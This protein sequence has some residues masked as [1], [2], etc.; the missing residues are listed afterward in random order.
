MGM[1]ATIKLGDYLWRPLSDSD[2]DTA[3]VCAL[4]NEGRF[5]RMFYSQQITPE[6]HKKFI[7]AADERDEINWLIQH[8]DGTPLGVSSIYHVDRANRK[9]ECGRTVMLDPRLFHMNFVA[10]G[11]IAQEV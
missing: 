5:A 8:T 2:A 4:R 9:C 11:F 10:S 6:M 1:R 7:R 3:F